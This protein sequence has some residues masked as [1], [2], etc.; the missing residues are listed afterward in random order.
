MKCP[1]CGHDQKVKYGLKCGGC[2]YRFTFNPKES[3]TK[4]LTDGKFSGCIDA[5]SQ[6]GTSYFTRN[7]FYAIYARRMSGSPLKQIGCGVVL[8]VG[9]VGFALA[10]LWPFAMV[11]TI[12]GVIVVIGGLV[13]AGRKI[14]PAQV[15]VLLD[16]WLTDGK[17]IDRLIEK[18]TLHDPPPE[19]SEPDIYDYGVERILIVERDVLVDLFVKNG[20]HAEQRM[21]IVGES[22]YPDYLL[23]VAQRLLTEQPD[24]PVF[25][26][27]DASSQGVRMKDRVLA[28][29]LLPLDG[30]PVTDLGMFPTDFQKLRRLKGYDPDNKDRAL[31][32]DA[33]ML[34]FMTMGLGAAMAGGITLGSMIE[35]QHQRRM[36]DAGVEFG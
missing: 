34:P 17:T 10:M 4:G 11:A 21:L 33:M 28:R 22:G 35:Q 1:E 19:W 9:A 2:R 25:L 6:N 16:R 13:E 7:Q 5:A 18:P 27:H 8:L 12:V 15:D 20:I 14:T 24:L 29:G 32:V 26:L 31:P 3:K 30:H 36:Y 23:P